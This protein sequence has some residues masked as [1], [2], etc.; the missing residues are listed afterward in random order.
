M[1]EKIKFFLFR[2]FFVAGLGQAIGHPMHGHLLGLS[3]RA[4]RLL[5]VF[6]T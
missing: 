5:M 6:H 4:V 1:P 2:T 3:V